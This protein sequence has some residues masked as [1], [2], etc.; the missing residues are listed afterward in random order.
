MLVASVYLANVDEKWFKT[1]QKRAGVTAA[2]IADIAGRSRTNVSHIY[3]GKQ[4]M[5]LHW[6]AAFAQAF[7][8]PVAE[9]L[10]KAG[11]TTPK[12]QAAIETALGDGDL[13]ELSL[14]PGDPANAICNLF[15]KPSQNLTLWRV[16]GQSLQL[17]GYIQG[18]TIALDRNQSE[19]CR[20]GDIVVAKI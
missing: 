19:T 2:D 18:D 11:V 9:I 14:P 5:S 8:L 12:T 7:G 4:K 1:Q 17:S 13:F 10:N 20:P 3:A 16:T 15:R 6:A